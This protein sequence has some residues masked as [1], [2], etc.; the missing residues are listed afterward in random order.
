MVRHGLDLWTVGAIAMLA[1]LLANVAHEGLG[2]GGVMP[3]RGR[4]AAG[5]VIG[6]VQR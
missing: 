3:A 6:L 5:A 4:A 1:Y 2:H